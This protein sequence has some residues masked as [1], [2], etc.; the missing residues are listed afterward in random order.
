MKNIL[1]LAQK[2]MFLSLNILQNFLKNQTFLQKLWQKQ[3]YSQVQYNF[4]AKNIFKIFMKREKNVHDCY[5]IFYIWRFCWLE[6]DLCVEFII[7]K[8]SIFY[9]GTNVF[10][11]SNY[12]LPITEQVNEENY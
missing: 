9:H 5:V 1:D 3:K 4:A 8:C 12:R 2:F 10:Y 11:I 7:T 6:R